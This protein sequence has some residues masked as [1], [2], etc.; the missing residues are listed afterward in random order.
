MQDFVDCFRKQKI[1]DLVILD[2]VMFSFTLTIL[3]QMTGADL[4]ET[5][6]ILCIIFMFYIM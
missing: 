1:G 5:F 3:L 6:I 4:I 2:Y